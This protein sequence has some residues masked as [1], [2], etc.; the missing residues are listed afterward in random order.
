MKIILLF[1][2]ARLSMASVFAQKVTYDLLSYT[3]PGL[4]QKEVKENTYTSYTVTNQQT[5]GYCQFSS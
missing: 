3:P 4:W 5:R 2:A 1:I